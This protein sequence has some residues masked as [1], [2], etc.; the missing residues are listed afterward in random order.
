[1]RVKPVRTC[2]F[3]PPDL[4]ADLK[5]EAAS[6]PGRTNQSAVAIEA[7]RE[8]LRKRPKRRKQSA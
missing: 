1:M 2:L 6:R 8:Y 4:L 7:L 3:F 5:A